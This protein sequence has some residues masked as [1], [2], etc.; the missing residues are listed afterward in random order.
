MSNWQFTRSER[1]QQRIVPWS[2]L[3]L[4]GGDVE[5]GD[6]LLSWE[7]NNRRGLRYVHVLDEAEARQMAGAAGLAVVEVFRSDGVTGDLADYVQMRK[8]G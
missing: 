8:S 1:L 7:R 3:N 6:Y 5:P 2:A 4:T